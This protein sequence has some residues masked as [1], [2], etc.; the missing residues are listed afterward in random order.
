MVN[1]LLD[2]YENI[3]RKGIIFSIKWVIWGMCLKFQSILK[4]KIL[5]SKY[6]IKFYANYSDATFR[7]YIFGGYG[8]FLNEF[9]NSISKPFVFLD[10]GA[11]QGL[12]SIIS[13][14]NSNCKKVISFEPIDVTY[15]FLNKN[16]SLNE[17]EKKCSTYQLA[18]SNINQKKK[19]SFNPNHTGSVSLIDRG[20]SN[21]KK[22]IETINSNS[23]DEILKDIN[24]DI[25]LKVDVEGYEH[26]VI[27]EF[28]KSN[29]SHLICGVFYEVDTRWVNPNDLKE[30]LKKFGFNK[31]K[32]I[33]NSK[34]HYDILTT[35]S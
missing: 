22:E 34:T 31:F 27:N 6:K 30:L 9:I 3:K 33:G 19:I 2:I 18:I 24:Q 7:L 35:K 5:L 16:I 11:N 8:N 28:F 13:A 23:I 20:N 10:V 25:Y 4:K 14:K 21:I 15:N 12:Y 32:T 29:K 26:V 1:K 17:V